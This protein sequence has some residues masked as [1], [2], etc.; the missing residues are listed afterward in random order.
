MGL[1]RT[2]HGIKL[3]CHSDG[4][5]NQLNGIGQQLP[6]Q[7]TEQGVVGA[8]ENDR[9]HRSIDQWLEVCLRSPPQ[10]V[11]VKIPGLD[12]GNEGWTGLFQ[13]H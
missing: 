1:R 11:A 6:K 3:P 10:I 12:Q 4:G 9:F 8:T 13:H 7:W 5:I 2:E